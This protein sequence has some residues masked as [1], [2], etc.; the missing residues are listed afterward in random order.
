MCVRT[1]TMGHKSHKSHIVH[2]VHIRLTQLPYLSNVKNR[3][4]FGVF[5]LISY[6]CIVKMKVAAQEGVLKQKIA[7]IKDK[8]C[9]H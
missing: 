3:H 8:K 2:I 4:P 9:A 1:R 7:N 5:K 6:L